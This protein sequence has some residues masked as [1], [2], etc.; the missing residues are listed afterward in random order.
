[1]ALGRGKDEI[2]VMMGE[3]G[4]FHVLTLMLMSG[5]T[6]EAAA[7][8][9]GRLAGTSDSAGREAQVISSE[10]LRALAGWPVLPVHVRL[11]AESCTKCILLV[12]CQ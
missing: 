6:T 2:I 1:M 3:E 8:C 4:M 12:A 5:S 9:L 10:L 7:A 11:Q